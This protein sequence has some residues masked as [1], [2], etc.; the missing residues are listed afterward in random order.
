MDV[1]EL[2]ADE[3]AALIHHHA[4]RRDTNGHILAESAK[5]VIEL[6]EALKQRYV[7]LGRLPA[8]GPE[9]MGY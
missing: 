4:G 5:R 9:P 1:K 8:S 2:Q 7:E 3:L 6:T